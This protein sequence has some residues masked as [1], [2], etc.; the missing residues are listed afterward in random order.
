MARR[1]WSTWYNQPTAE[2]YHVAADTRF[3]YWLEGAQQDSGAVGV[4]TWSRFG[5]LD[6]PQL[7]AAMPGRRERI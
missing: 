5:V 2:I 7:G 4:A 6:Y 3:P 1:P